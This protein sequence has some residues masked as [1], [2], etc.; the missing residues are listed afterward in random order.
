MDRRPT[1]GVPFKRQARTPAGSSI[2]TNPQS[3]LLELDST[4]RL[5]IGEAREKGVM[6]SIDDTCATCDQIWNEC[7]IAT[8]YK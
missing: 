5:T 3:W 7:P 6:D 1:Q 8:N 2:Y 4:P